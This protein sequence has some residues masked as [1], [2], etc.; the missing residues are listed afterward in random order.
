M[1]Y[2]KSIK[3]IE[4]ELNTN[5]QGL[6]DEEAKKRTIIHGK[7]TLPKHKKESVIKIFFSE[8]KDP[9][10]ILLLVA[11][12]ASFLVGETVDA[13]AILLIVLIDVLMGTY[14]E[15]KANNTAEALAEL[16]TVKTKVIRNGKIIKIES[17]DITIGDIILLESGDKISADIRLTET[18]NLTINES[19][20]TGE[21]LEI[22]KNHEKIT[23]KN[24]NI[25]EQTNMAFAGSTVVKGRAKG[26]VVGIGLNT[27]IG[28]IATSIQETKEEKS[29]LTIRVEKLSKQ[30]SMLVIIVGI[31][32]AL[33]ML[34]KGVPTHELFLSVIALSVSAMPEGLPLSLTMALTIASNKMASKNVVVKKLNSVESLGSCT[35]I[36]SDKTGTLTVNEQT[37]KKI[38]M[39]NGEEFTVTGVGYDF[40]G[41]VDGTNLEYAEEIALLGVINNE[42]IVKE[43]KKVGDSIDI[44]FKVLG[45]KLD[46]KTTGITILES[47]PYESENKYSAVFYEKDGNCY[48]TIKGSV[49]KVASFCKNLYLTKEKISTNHL[50][51]QNEYLASDGYR[52]IGVAAGKIS[53]KENYT[54]KDIKNLTFMGMVGF[55]DPIRKEVIDSIKECKTAG[56]KVLMI[57]GDHPLTA[58]SIAKELELTTDIN[59][60][61]SGEEVEKYLKKGK[62]DFDK[63]IKTKSVYAR[64]TP[65][66]KLEIVESLKRQGEFVAVTGDGVNDAPALKSANIGISMGSGTDLARET[67]KM[68]IIDDNFKSIVSAVKQ[69]RVAYSNI[70]KIIYFLLSCGMA[71]V[72]FFILSIILDL[73]MPLVAIQ[74]LWLNVVTDGIQDLALSF[75]K[76][77]PGIMKEKPRNPKESIFDKNL[78]E[79]IA[80]SALIIGILVFVVWYYLIKILRMEVTM[81]RGYIMALMVFIQNI[82]VFNCRSEKKSAFFVSIKN[83]PFIVV[84][85]ILTILLQIIVMESAFMTKIL[86]T[87]SIPLFNL[88]CL[89]VLSLVILFIMEI[90]KLIKYGKPNQ[91]EK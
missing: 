13:F 23:K 8:F 55:I 57:T 90:Y 60:V 85:V 76:A 6:T 21:S 16:V 39:P 77:E 26:I 53:K 87:V 43:D 2:N 18:H 67:S 89:F 80:V 47:I 20:I 40:N 70:R 81:A 83:N 27:E 32:I 5:E 7:N 9:I 79:E 29:P 78:I 73:P 65:L 22:N 44:A 45:N 74:L 71:E 51:N 14:Q 38:L 58:F 61:A 69:G 25:A 41:H 86:Q 31:I 46:I 52:V 35:V 37:A 62:K 68:I 64:V 15:N 24:I 63:F 75:E 3:E 12:I 1:Y 36:A 56:I 28:H 4:K 30:I 54:E 48:C 72:L 42:A 10:V 49:E 33:L 50:E 88:I 84:G 66:Q 19:V 17:E 59:K 82:H 34:A 11:I 91:K